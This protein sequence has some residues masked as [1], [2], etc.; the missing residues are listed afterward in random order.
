MVTHVLQF[1][2]GHR[3][4]YIYILCYVLQFCFHMSYAHLIFGIDVGF[5]VK[6]IV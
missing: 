6:P 3:Y 1:V 2:H 5:I 4:H